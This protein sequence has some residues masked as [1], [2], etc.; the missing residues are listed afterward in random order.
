MEEEEERN[1]LSPFFLLF[2]WR[3][4]GP[5]FSF[6]F[7]LSL[8]TVFFLSLKVLSSSFLFFSFFP[9]FPLFVPKNSVFSTSL[10]RVLCTVSFS[11]LL[12]PKKLNSC[13]LVCR[14]FLLKKKVFWK[15]LF[16]MYL[17]DYS[18]MKF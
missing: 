1:C 17:L 10:D 3:I 12:L 15:G 11:V 13:L 2:K 6:S 9:F 14:L 5:S 18:K 8:C 4:E 7:S 16:Q